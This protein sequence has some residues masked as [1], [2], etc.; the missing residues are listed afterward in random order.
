MDAVHVTRSGFGSRYP[1]RDF[2]ARYG[3]C[4]P[5]AG[6]RSDKEVCGQVLRLMGLQDNLYRMGHGKMFLKH[7]VIE[8]LETRRSEMLTS[9]V[10]SI[11]VNR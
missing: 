1:Y 4:A 2:L 3:C 8:L 7:N 10:L 6:G 11:Q 5:L 9:F